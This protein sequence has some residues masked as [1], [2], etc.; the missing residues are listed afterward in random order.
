[1]RGQPVRRVRDLKASKIKWISVSL[2]G[3]GFGSALAIYLIA[4]PDSDDPL[5]GD[6]LMTKRYVHD[7]GVIG[8]KSNVMI[9]EFIDWFESLWHGQTLAGTVAVLTVFATL[10]F[11]FVALRPHLFAP[12]A[13]L[14]KKP[15]LQR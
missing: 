10:V 2:L 14:N 11:R 7:L 12:A 13:D 8:G 9:A 3:I 15:P 1:M 4:R 6:P 5:L